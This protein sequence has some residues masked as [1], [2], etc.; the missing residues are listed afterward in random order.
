MPLARSWFIMLLRHYS[1]MLHYSNLVSLWRAQLVYQTAL[2][3]FFCLFC[4]FF[5]F[6]MWGKE[7]AFSLCQHRIIFAECSKNVEETPHFCVTGRQ[8]GC[9]TRTC[10]DVPYSSL[11]LR[12]SRLKA[13]IACVCVFTPQQYLTANTIFVFYS[14]YR[15]DIHFSIDDHFVILIICA[16]VN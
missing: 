9:L 15:S 4:F 7:G 8:C 10:L 16:L 11:Y 12:R 3:L 5:N 2:C 14:F 13:S 1:E 6:Y